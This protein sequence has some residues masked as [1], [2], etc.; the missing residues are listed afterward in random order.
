LQYAYLSYEVL[1]PAIFASAGGAFLLLY[2]N[3]RKQLA[4]L[5]LAGAYLLSTIGF[6]AV[7]LGD[8]DLHKGYQV[9]ILFSLFSGHFLLIWGVASLFGKDVPKLAFWLAAVVVAGIAIYSSSNGS[10]FWLR[11]A[12]VSGFIAFVDLMC[13]VLVWR[14]RSHRVDTVVAGLFLMQVLVIANRT[15]LVLSS[16]MDLSTHH[17]FKKSA[18]AASMQTENAI[19][20]IAIGLALFARYSVTLVKQLQLL[21]ETDPL[22]G[23]L[24]RRA[25]EDR[26]QAL[27][28]SSAPLSTGLI[29]CDIDH[30]KRVTDRHGHEVGDRA[31]KAFS[32]LL[33]RE[34]PETAICTRLGGEEFC[35]LLPG[36]TDEMIRLQATHLRGAVERL[37]ISTKDDCLRLTASFG[38][39]RLD[40]DCDLMTAMADVDAAVYQAKN[41]GRNL[42]R[43]AGPAVHDADLLQKTA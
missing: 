28:A 31:L 21:A 25:F 9:A 34:T 43:R 8:A 41:D 14:A 20:A 42:V 23:L 33:E 30:F 13:C 26:V 12:A 7:M 3:D 4:A 10:L 27:R 17:A 22:T 11:Y 36:A 18:F 24:N 39:C 32:Q 1:G 19:F 15:L 38:Y 5:R 40:P 37:K 29:I 6:V 35:I 2:L 16:G